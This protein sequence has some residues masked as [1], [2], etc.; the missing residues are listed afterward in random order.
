M[1][2]LYVFPV[3]LGGLTA[4]SLVQGYQ[5]L[6]SQVSPS[7]PSFS[8][9]S[10]PSF[11]EP[12]PSP[13]PSPIFT[14]APTSTPPFESD[15][16]RPQPWQYRPRP[17]LQTPV[18][19]PTL[20][21]EDARN[22]LEEISEETGVNPAIIYIN[23]VPGQLA[24][25]PNFE[26]REAQVT[27]DF[28]GHLNITEAQETSPSI[29]FS[30]QPDDQLEILML[31]A[32]G[33]AVRKRVPVTRETVLA[34]GDELRRAVTNPGR[35]T[36]FLAPAQQFYRWLVEP[37]LEDLE[38]RNIEN[39]VFILDEGLRSLPLA[40]LHDGEGFIIENYSVGLMPSLALT[41]TRYVNIQNL[42]VLAMG[43][44]EFA[45]QDPL[46][47]VP[48]EL[49]LITEQLWPGRFL[50][51]QDFTVRN[52]T[53]IRQ[54]TPYGIV[55]L[56]THGEF[57]SGSPENS[58]IQFSDGPLR[59][60]AIR[61]LGFNNPPVELLV[62][63][64]CRTALGDTE[65]ELGFAGLAA[66]A[67]VKTALGSLW[68]VSDAGTLAFMVSFYE[69]LRQVPIKAEA[70]RQAQLAMAQGQARLE[71]GQLVTPE[72]T[73]PLTPELVALGDREL[74]HPYYWSAFTMIGSPW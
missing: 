65:A 3:L 30:P 54:Q 48:L 21:Q 32:Q 44:A 36:A 52:L 55:H 29:T 18:F 15:S 60:D 28:L 64:A 74:T 42:Q 53:E 61:R 23:F 13:I 41:D 9:P 34:Q 4:W 67:G 59:L 11:S 35:A 49:E 14:P 40:T 31:T 57:Q 6:L 39:L 16:N 5:P 20:Q 26:Q 70:L 37:L 69:Q 68:Y 33:D 12:S 27:R 7:D 22:I 17:T 8:G 72:G 43:A 25:S 66:K 51:N 10:S 63:S 24:Y 2:L 62:L 73:F 47:G 50:L 58:F 1:K 71:G 56:G 46:P 19:V 38:A 45:T